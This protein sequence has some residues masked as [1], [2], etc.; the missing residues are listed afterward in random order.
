MK[1]Y[2]RGFAF[3][4]DRSEALLIRKSHPAWQAGM[5][6][7]IG[8]HVEP[9]EEPIHAMVREFGEETGVTTVLDWEQVC[10]IYRLFDFECHVFRAIV[11]G[12]LDDTGYRTMTDEPVVKARLPLSPHELAIGN[13]H[14]LIPLCVD[15]NDG[16]EPYHVTGIIKQ[17]GEVQEESDE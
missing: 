6:N 17:V 1:K 4:A 15:T 2:V 9:G 13:L 5:L 12:S 16:W 8:G 14:W 3:S 7:G 11:P 10:I